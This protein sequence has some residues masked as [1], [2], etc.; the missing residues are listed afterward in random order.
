MRVPRDLTAEPSPT[1]RR[2]ARWWLLGLLVVIIILAVSLRSLAGIY[3]DSLWFDSVNYHDVFS[4]LLVI[5]LGLDRK[6]V[7]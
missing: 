3:T 6:S 1:R 4:T 7:V 2:R 5:K